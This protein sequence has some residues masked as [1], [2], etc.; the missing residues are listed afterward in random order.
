MF[1]SLIRLFTTSAPDFEVLW[2]GAKDLIAGSNP[3][4]NPQIFTGI[5]YP[6]N[7]LFFYVP[8]TFLNYQ[9]AQNVFTALSLVSLVLIIYLSMRLRFPKIDK[10]TFVLFLV[11][12]LLFFPTKFT[13]G[14]G[15]N[16]LIAFLILLLSYF[17]Y[18]KGRQTLSG[19]LLGVAI[20]FKTVFGIFILFYILKKQFKIILYA[21]LTI[22]VFTM[23]TSSVS[24]L[25][26]GLYKFYFTNIIPPLL[27]FE[28]RGIFYNQGIS[29]FIARVISDVGLIK[30]VWFATSLVFLITTAFLTLKKKKEN[31]QFSLFLLT[32][33][34]IDSLSWQHHFVWTLF[35][36]AILFPAAFLAV[37]FLLIGIDFH[38]SLNFL[39]VIL[40]YFYNARKIAE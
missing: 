37:P 28:G 5:G 26:A 25:G 11:L 27:N 4:I 29:G 21:L 19:V 30:L 34:L 38:N 32:L 20:S 23:V 18:R 40:L 15:Q 1:N 8:L 14:M 22:A 13:L 10:L 12:S 2:L 24:P 39:G 31:L 35:S 9:T 33:L 7:T 3:Y 6:P 36:F 16:N 17:F